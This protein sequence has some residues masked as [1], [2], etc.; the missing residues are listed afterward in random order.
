MISKGRPAE[1]SESWARW[2]PLNDRII[3]KGEGDGWSGTLEEQ[4]GFV[5][6]RI[7]KHF[8]SVEG[9]VNAWKGRGGEKGGGKGNFYSRREGT[10]LTHFLA[11]REKKS[12]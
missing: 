5:G 8:I 12:P 10:V 11:V 4:R 3:A 2:K 7:L 6:A 1:S 9:E